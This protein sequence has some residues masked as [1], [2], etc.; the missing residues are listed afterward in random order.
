MENAYPYLLVVGLLHGM[1][2]IL[3]D[4]E[5]KWSYEEDEDENLLISI[6]AV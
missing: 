3:S 1:F 5:G 4:R 2:E 6:E